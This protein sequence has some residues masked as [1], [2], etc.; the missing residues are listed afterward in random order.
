MHS[1]HF[2]CFECGHVFSPMEILFECPDCSGPLDIEYDYGEI[3]KTLRKKEFLKKPVSHWKYAAF[4][5]IAKKEKIVSLNEGGT[6]LIK[7]VSHENVFFK[8]EGLNPTGSFKDRGS[9]VEISKAVELGI[10]KVHCASTGNMGASVAA[11]CARAGIKAIIVVPRIA[12]ERKVQQML[13]HNAEVKRVNGDYT[14]ALNIVRKA[15]KQGNAYIVG[16]YPFRGEGEK[17]VGFE[18]AEQFAW[19]APEQVVCPMGN[20]TLIYAVFKA[21]NELKI[22]GFVKKTPH[23]VGVQAEKCDPIVKAFEKHGE[24]IEIK[25][26]ET[27]ATAIACGKPI[28]GIMALHAIKKSKGTAA[29][30]SDREILEAQK[31]LARQ[32]IYAEPSG[33]AGFAGLKKTSAEKTTAVIVTGHGLKSDF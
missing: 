7:S 17:S 27:V 26:P 32:G 30:V 12:E 5:P 6:P 21:F 25:N 24:I 20:G 15:R 8:F 33:A 23:L 11:Y 19:K 1:K 2:Y 4:F 3:R 22:T 13:A 29:R 16:D 31:A 14:A 18:I 10:K 9:T 28:D